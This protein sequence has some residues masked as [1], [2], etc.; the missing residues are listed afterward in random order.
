[1]LVF[2]F[3]DVFCSYVFEKGINSDMMIFCAAASFVLGRFFYEVH[4]YKVSLFR[5]LCLFV[6]T[7]RLATSQ[8]CYHFPV[9]FW[10]G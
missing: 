3:K 4:M 1:M 2:H 9:A 5:D 10:L 8:L 6:Q 7:N